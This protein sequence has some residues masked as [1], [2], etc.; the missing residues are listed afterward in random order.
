MCLALRLTGLLL[1]LIFKTRLQVEIFSNAK[2]FSDLLVFTLCTVH[3]MLYD[4]FHGRD[5]FI[6]SRHGKCSVLFFFC[7]LFLSHFL[8]YF[9]AIGVCE[10]VR[11]CRYA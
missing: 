4:C 6:D 11:L 5:C 7:D 1:S 8:K 9:L 2:R 3:V 10:C